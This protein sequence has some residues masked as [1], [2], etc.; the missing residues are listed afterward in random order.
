MKTFVTRIFKPGIL[1]D[2]QEVNNETN[3]NRPTGKFR[4]AKKYK[5]TD[6]FICGKKVKNKRQKNK[7]GLIRYNIVL[8]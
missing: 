1:L 6:G 7:I 3:S 2:H 8:V 5:M 4:K